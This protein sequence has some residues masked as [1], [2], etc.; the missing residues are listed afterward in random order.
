M[1]SGGRNLQC[2]GTLEAQ[3]KTWD[4]VV[5]AEF[6]QCVPA[7][8]AR[9]GV[10]AAAFDDPTETE[11][12]VWSPVGLHVA[13]SA[14]CE[15]AAPPLEANTAAGAVA[16]GGSKCLRV[17]AWKGSAGCSSNPKCAALKQWPQ[18]LSFR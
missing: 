15:A 5:S 1:G 3:V 4:E 11:L 6:S 17:I 2:Q 10:R 12:S 7:A 13:S 8:A 16:T 9:A 14:S 18:D